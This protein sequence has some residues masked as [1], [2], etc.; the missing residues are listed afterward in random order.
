M[1]FELWGERPRIVVARVHGIAMLLAVVA[2]ALPPL[3]MAQA[4]TQG[5]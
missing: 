5:L 4:A 3:A 1:A 2:V